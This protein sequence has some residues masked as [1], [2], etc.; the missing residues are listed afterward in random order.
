PLLLVLAL[1][2]TLCL[3]LVPATKV[4]AANATEVK[5]GSATLDST[6]RFLVRGNAEPNGILGE[7]GC[8]AELRFDAGG[9]ATLYLENAHITGVAGE[10][11][12]AGIHAKGELTINFIGDNT[13]DAAEISSS[14]SYGIRIEESSDDSVD[15]NLTLQGKGSLT[16]TSADTSDSFSFG[17]FAKN[18]LTIESGEIIATAGRGSYSGGI[19]AYEDSLSIKGGTVTAT[20]GDNT[21]ALSY[22]IEAYGPLNITGGT[23]TATGGDNAG[24]NTNDNSYGIRA[25]GPVSISKGTVNATGG[26]NSKGNSYGIEAVDTF[27]IT[28][29][30]VTATGGDNANGAS[31]GLSSENEDISIS[32]GT[33]TAK[34]GSAVGSAGIYASSNSVFISGNS[35]K[36]TAEGGSATTGGSFGINADKSV[37]VDGGTVEATGGSA[38]DSDSAGIYSDEEDIT[39]S[40]SDTVVTAKGGLGEYSSGINANGPDNGMDRLLSIKGGSVTAIG[41]DDAGSHSYGIVT[42]KDTDLE[43]SGGTVTAIGGND[44]G[45]FSYGLYSYSANI[46]LSGGTVTATGGDGAGKWSYGINTTNAVEIKNADVKATGGKNARIESYGINAENDFRLY[47]GKLIART[48]ETTASEKK[49]AFNKAPTFMP[50][51]NPPDYRW[52]LAATDDYTFSTATSYTRKVTDKYVE[53]NFLPTFTGTY[54]IPA[55]LINSDIDA[56]QL[57]AAG[58]TKPYTFSKVSGPDWLEVSNDGKITGKRPD[59]PQP[60]TTAVL[61]VTD[62]NSGSET[63]TIQVGAVNLYAVIEGADSEWIKGSDKALGFTAN[64]PFNKLVS[65][66]VDG[67]A[68]TPNQ[69]YT[70]KE[71]STIVTLQPAYLETLAA[72][73]H[74][75]AVNYTDGSAET[76]FTI[77]AQGTPG[78]GDD[79]AAKNGG[80]AKTGDNTPVGLYLLLCLM[81]LAAIAA[82]MMTLRHKRQER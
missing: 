21:G 73:E 52:R 11:R 12:S 79:P 68:I 9:K 2:L 69:D 50:Q 55:G 58:G 34:G 76:T 60:A 40:G 51:D 70:A 35:T 74:L 3:W 17:I 19:Q 18:N 53:I 15:G 80:N 7:D 33:V 26:D 13:V 78:S 56:I 30:T 43:I 66:S 57:E 23:I 14:S 39:I 59:S 46:L 64:G 8:T 6:N 5:V 48:L 10:N 25:H 16:V 77:L 45:S 27:E 67:K 28:N 42:E 75:L 31:V 81:A 29:G 1:V 44:A 47:S 41:G 54:D 61:N 65:V 82:T 38:S 24:T 22:G 72:G 71:G 37:T 62:R 36:V 49:N 4:Q 63:I 32:G 20:G